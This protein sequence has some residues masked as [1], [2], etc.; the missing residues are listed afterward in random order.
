MTEILA[1]L[2]QDFVVERENIGEDEILTD[3]DR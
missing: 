3:E 1:E 2:R